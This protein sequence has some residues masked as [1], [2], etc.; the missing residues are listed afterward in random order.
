MKTEN[1]TPEQKYRN[2][3]DQ[4]RGEMRKLEANNPQ[5]YAEFVEI[6]KPYSAKFIKSLKS[7]KPIS[8]DTVDELLLDTMRNNPPYHYMNSEKQKHEHVFTFS[9]L[10]IPAY[11]ELRGM[12]ESHC[13]TNGKNVD[14]LTKQDL[15]DLKAPLALVSRLEANDLNEAFAMERERKSKEK[16]A[17]KGLD[18]ENKEKE[19]LKKQ[20]ALKATLKKAK[21]IKQDLKGFVEKTGSKTKGIMK[22]VADKARGRG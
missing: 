6:Q 8:I 3:L 5:V 7:K 14:Q 1:M 21:S 17:P 12:V 20:S 2:K 11:R 9:K 22:K 13:A 15:Q 18:Q 16:E 10:E 19:A 4:W